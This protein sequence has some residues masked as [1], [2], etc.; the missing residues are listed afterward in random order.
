MFSSLNQNHSNST[1]DFTIF[2]NLPMFIHW[3][4]CMIRPWKKS[5]AFVNRLRGEGQLE[6]DDKGPRRILPE[7]L[8]FYQQKWQRRFDPKSRGLKLPK[9]G[10]NSKSCEIH[11]PELGRKEQIMDFNKAQ[12]GIDNSD[13]DLVSKDWDEHP[14]Q[15]DILVWKSPVFDVHPS[16]GCPMKCDFLPVILGYMSH[17]KNGVSPNQTFVFSIKTRPFQPEFRAKALAQPRRFS[18]LFIPGLKAN[19]FLVPGSMP[20]LGW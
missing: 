8:G 20:P 14:Q 11:Q 3:Q 7:K 9:I 6:A 16:H 4:S 15:L 12:V 18:R 10:V 1:Y 19:Q 13:W 2:S 17:P 5:G